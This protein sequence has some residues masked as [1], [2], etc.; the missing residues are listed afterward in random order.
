MNTLHH[1]P[2]RADATFAL[3]FESLRPEPFAP[4]FLLSDDELFDRG[5]RRVIASPVPG[6]NYPCRVSLDFPQGGEELLLVNHRHL[7]RDTTPYRA[8]GPVFVRRLAQ[9]YARLDEF[10]P[11]IL[12]REM[13]VRAYDAEGMMIEADL[14]AKEE[15]KV[16]TRVW[17]ARADVAHVDFHSA[18]RGC[19]FAR[20][21]R[22]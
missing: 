3:R 10:P 11:I 22:A 16:L 18:R 20:V 4:L 5:M 2:E 15:L 19:F 12:Q 1:A 17:L 7:D 14:A 6:I 13:A 8:E 21:R 9:A